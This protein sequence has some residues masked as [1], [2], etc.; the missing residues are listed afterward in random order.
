MNCGA[1][2]LLNELLQTASSTLIIIFQRLPILN[3][4]NRSLLVFKVISMGTFKNFNIS[5]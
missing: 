2:S 1:G 3:I 4:Y 5:I